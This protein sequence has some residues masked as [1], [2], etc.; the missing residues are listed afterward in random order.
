[1]TTY[2]PPICTGCTRFRNDDDERLTCDAFPDGIPDAILTSE[3]D[4]RKAYKG[5]QGLRFDPKDLDAARYAK[6]I[7]D[8]S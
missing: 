8:A 5:D 4:H 2:A 1:M 7:L 6:T 3:A